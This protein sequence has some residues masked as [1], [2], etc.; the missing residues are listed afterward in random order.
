MSWQNN[1]GDRGPW[2]QGPKKGGGGGNGPPDID[3]LIRKGQDK[4][5]NAF[6]GGN[7]GSGGSGESLGGGK[8]FSIIFLVLAGI[9]L[10]M[11]TYIVDTDEQA[12]ELR[13]GKWTETNDPGLHFH[14]VP[15]EEV[16]LTKV[17]AVNVIQ[18]GFGNTVVG[19]KER[20]ML[21]GDENIVDAPFSVLWRIKDPAAFHFNL[22]D[23]E[24]SIKSIAESAMREVV[25]KTNVENVMTNNKNG[26]ELEVQQITQDIL[27][28]YVAGIE[29]T[30]V[31]MEDVKP[32]A[33]I[34]DAFNDVQK[35]EA[36]RDRSISL[37]QL[38]QNKIVPQARGEAAK[39]L[40]QAEAYKSKEIA[41]AEGETSRFEAILSEYSK[42]KDVTRRRIYLDTM[43]QVLS[44]TNKVVIDGDGGSGVVPYL[45]LTELQ[46]P[47]TS[48][49]NNPSSQ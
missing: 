45:P 47:N 33:E 27:N 11:S 8:S 7:G 37:A 40:Q 36:D 10:Y 13:F 44:G 17:T 39:M 26:I 15:F 32:P 6:G 25:A 22:R 46:K 43:Q 19:Q 24:V 29:I 31:K 28:G 21:T 2:G 30:Q 12:I 42:A 49:N 23:R 38:E 9:W 5:K 41:E 14:F 1:G 3:E 16:I 34:S 35:A 48:S 18:I 20:Q 4:F